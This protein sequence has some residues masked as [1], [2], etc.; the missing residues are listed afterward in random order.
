M[1]T[2][3]TSLN[4]RTGKEDG[5][6]LGVGG[7]QAFPLKLKTKSGIRNRPAEL[8]MEGRLAQ[9]QMFWWV[10]KPTLAWPQVSR[11]TFLSV[12]QLGSV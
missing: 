10:K 7:G 6:V 8:A 9:K 4:L 2:R 12:S 5:G 3:S 11:K 1:K